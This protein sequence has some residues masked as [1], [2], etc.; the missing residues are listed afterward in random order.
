MFNQSDLNLLLDLFHLY[1]PSGKEKPVLDF[2]KLVLDEEEIKYKQDDKG[3]IYCLNYKNTPLLSSHT[4]C[5]GTAES[6]AYVNLID[7]LC[8]SFLPL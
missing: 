4:D 8:H 5:V 7:F 1:A 3:N 2:I 6:G